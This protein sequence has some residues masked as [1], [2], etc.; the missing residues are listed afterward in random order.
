MKKAF[1]TGGSRGIGKGI[2]SCLAADGYDVVFTYRSKKEEAEKLVEDL[3]GEYGVKC[4]AIQAALEEAGEGVRAFREAVKF[5]D[6]LTLLVNNAGV[7]IFESILDL[8][9]EKLDY[10]FALDFRNYI[11]LMREATRYMI[12]RDIKGSIVNITS[13]RSQ[14]AYPGDGIYGGL[15]AG[16]NRA[17]QSFALDVASYGIRINNVA[18]GAIRIRSAEEIK[19]DY[20][21]SIPTTFWDDLA[22]VIP[23]ER[24]GTP[25]DIGN[26]VIFLAS[27]KASYITGVT[28]NVDGGLILP[29]MPEKT[30][31]S[32]VAW[33][34]AEKQ[35]IEYEI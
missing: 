31:G 1:V 16:L 23:I 29:G 14:R 12:S 32:P 9:E 5:L 6:G 28:I 27:E 30:D 22:K 13:T 26:A 10:L 15:K 11:I 19:R 18:P 21:D 25:E 33:G 7:T 3:T 2:A 34:A 35:K 20:G 24:S 8:T 17:I 4:L